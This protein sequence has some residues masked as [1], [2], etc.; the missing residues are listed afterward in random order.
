MQFQDYYKTLGLKRNAS[1]EEIKK[2]YRLMAKKYHPDVSKEP[3][4]EEKFKQAKEAYEVLKDPE[5]RKAYDQFGQ[6]WQQGQGFQPPPDWNFRQSQQHGH[7]QPED[8]S[9]FFSEMFGGGRQRAHQRRNV[10]QRGEDQRSKI[11]ISLPEAFHGVTKTLNIREPQVDPRTGQIH[12]ENKQL[13]VKIPAGTTQHQQIRLSGQGAP[14]M[15]GGPNGDLYL[16]I[17][18]QPHAHYLVEGRDLYL[19]LPITPWEAALGGTIEVPTLAGSVNLKIPAGSQS[20][21]K[22]R[23]KGRGLPGK[24]P[25]DQYVILHIHVQEPKDAKQRALYEQMAQE[26]QFNPRAKII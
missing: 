20:G 8:F 5:K 16:E 13:N 1:A 4:A 15:N 3:N 17:E 23:L 10:R 22:L 2:S 14:G 21:Q 25:G 7:A 26:M 11:T 18:L 12:Y 9:D 19:N 6:N 24:T